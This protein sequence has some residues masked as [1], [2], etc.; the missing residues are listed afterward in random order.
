MENR[1]MMRKFSLA[2]LAVAIACPI[3]VARSDTADAAEYR[4]G[5][6]G[7][8]YY[9]KS[10]RDDYS[11]RDDAQYAARAHDLDPAGDYKGYPNWARVAL[12]PKFD[13]GGSRR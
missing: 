11:R 3:A 12:S 7:Q 10:K 13:G 5:S 4:R 6:A 9:R 8:K 1:S 2:L